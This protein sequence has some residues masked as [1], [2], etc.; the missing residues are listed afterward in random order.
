MRSKRIRRQTCVLA[1]I[2]DGNFLDHKFGDDVVLHEGGDVLVDMMIITE[3]DA[4]F[5]PVDFI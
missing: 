3:L 5:H 4:V 1:L 2:V